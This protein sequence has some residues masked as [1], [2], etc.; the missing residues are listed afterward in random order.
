[1]VVVDNNNMCIKL[2]NTR[3]KSLAATFKVS[4]E[5]RDICILDRLDALAV[6]LPEDE[7]IQFFSTRYY[8]VLEELTCIYTN[9]KCECV[10]FL[11]GQLFVSFLFASPS[12]IEI[13]S[14]DGTVIKRLYKDAA[15]NPLFTW[16]DYMA[17]FKDSIFISNYWNSSVMKI[18]HTGSVLNTYIDKSLR[19]PRGV[20]PT[21]EDGN[22]LICSRFSHTIHLI[23]S[24][25]EKLGVLLNE[26]DGLHCPW[27]VCFN[28]ENK[29][30]FVS[31]YSAK[32]KHGDYI[33][34][35][36]F[37]DE[38]TDKDMLGNDAETDKASSVPPRSANTV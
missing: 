11:D 6:T 12:R 25:C 14:L 23:S 24:E 8:N 1:M 2:V 7:R 35:Y 15:G 30:L 13:M 38:D 28:P 18:S 36:Q 22:V 29:T 16:P 31:S 32:G 5:P 34:V 27:S 20:T 19:W 26:S 10:E 17:V 37:V 4:C 33:R 3:D 21:G 9:G